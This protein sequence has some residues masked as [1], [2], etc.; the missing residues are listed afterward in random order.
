MAMDIIQRGAV[1]GNGSE[2]DAL[3]NQK[4]ILPADGGGVRGFAEND[5][6]DVLGSPYLLSSEVDVDYRT[7]TA[8]DMLLDEENF[9]YTAQNTGKF[10]NVATTMSAAWA[11]GGMNTNSGNITTTA[12]GIVGGSYAYFPILGTNTLQVDMA[13]SFS[14][15]PTTNTVIDFG[16][17]I[18]GA[19]NP[20]APTDGAYF[21]L[22]SAGLQG[23]VNYNGTETTTSV[24]VTSQTNQTPWTYVNNRRYQFIVYLTPRAV[25]FWI[26]DAGTVNL[27]GKI[28]TPA[29]NG[30]PF[31]SSA[32]PVSWR[33]SIV[34]GAASAV[35][36][37]QLARYSVRQGGVS[38]FTTTSTQGNRLYGSYQGLSGGT[39]GTNQSIGT[40]TAGNAANPTAA[41]PTTTTAALGTGLGGK[42]WETA[43]LAVNTDAIVMQ[44]QVPAGTAV[45]P[46]R[47]LVLSGLYLSSY[48]QTAITGGPFIKEWFLA[49]GHTAVSLAT[50]YGAGTKAPVRIT[51]PFVQTVTSAQA[52][53]TAVANTTNFVDFGDAP[54]FVNP[55]EFIQLCTRTV[56][57]VGT[58]GVIAHQVTPVYGWE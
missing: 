15:Q 29:G 24:F 57:T 27:Y 36:N 14:S 58:A 35:Q 8:V 42:F 16:A 11:T 56:G 22:T 54:I 26:N 39:I 50:T 32:L 49:F 53:S 34:G 19:A 45:S 48:I 20:Y 13:A 41:V 2:V 9:C 55:G 31:A 17:F 1:S 3:G 23:V 25:L 4:V 7:R 38:Q 6:G 10:T 37:F 44:F 51:L 47:R 12:T 28:E 30:Q 21:R 18:R 33:H 40:I 43:T 52:A 46:G 5:A